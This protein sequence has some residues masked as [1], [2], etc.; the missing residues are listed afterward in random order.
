MPDT[1]NDRTQ[2]AP[3]G[4][5]CHPAQ[6]LT[7]MSPATA[8]ARG[9]FTEILETL[10]RTSDDAAATA[11][12]MSDQQLRDIL[13]RMPE[14]SEDHSYIPSQILAKIYADA[15]AQRPSPPEP[16]PEP[17]KSDDEIVADELQLKPELSVDDLLRIR[18]EYALTNHPDR[19]AASLREQATR[20]MT[21][22]NMLIDQAV[23][24]KKSGA[25]P[26]S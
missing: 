22:A 9:D 19:V 18:R 26:R 11:A 6:G 2:S 20:R 8:S 14:F 23:R 25:P 16:L 21:I 15:R 24:Q 3:S 17:P 10:E 5:D 4:H 13:D 1:D 7:T 12:K